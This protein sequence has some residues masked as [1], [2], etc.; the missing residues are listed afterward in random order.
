MTCY[1]ISLSQQLAQMA[2]SVP[3]ILDTPIT[4][5]QHFS[6][7]R[8]FHYLFPI[9]AFRAFLFTNDS[10]ELEVFLVDFKEFDCQSIILEGSP[11]VH[12]PRFA[13]TLTKVG[14]P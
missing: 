10:F 8:F 9:F 3:L 1:L 12:V 13:P 7:R 14:C 11:C 2:Q 5:C 4:Q 6:V